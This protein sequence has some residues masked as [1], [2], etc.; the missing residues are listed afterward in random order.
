MILD[1]LYKLIFFWVVSLV[2]AIIGYYLLW[3]IMPEHY[4]FGIWFRMFLYHY[5]HPIQYILIPC[6]FFGILATIF[7]EKFSRQILLKQLQILILISSIT[8]LISSPFGGILWNYHDMQAGYF[9]VNWFEKM[10][11]NGIEMGLFM[12]WLIVALSIPYNLLGLLTCFYIMK[13][14]SNLFIKKQ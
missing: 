10:V 11:K 6:F 13:F 4:V 14:G 3:Y 5:E 1:K 7:L 12:G 2:S 8:I 9:P